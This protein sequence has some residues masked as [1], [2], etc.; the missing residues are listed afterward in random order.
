M[1]KAQQKI[2]A[3]YS[4]F[5]S[6]EQK[7]SSIDD[8]ITDCK[9]LADRE[10]YKV[11]RQLIFTDKA[12]SGTSRFDRDGMADLID[13]IRARKFDVLLCESQ[14]RLARDIEDYAFL[15]KRLK[16]SE[17]ILH[18][19]HD[20]VVA[21]DM[22]GSM[23][24][25]MDAEFIATLRKNVRRGMNGRARLGLR[26][27]QL[28]YGYRLVAGGKPGEWEIDPE[29]AKIVRRIFTEYANEVGVRDIA[30]GLTRDG[31]PTPK[32]RGGVA[33][34]HQAFLGGGDGGMLTNRLYIGE[35]VWGKQYIVKDL[36]THKANKRWR[37]ESEWIVTAVPHLRIISQE[38]WD[39]VQRLRESRTTKH[40]P[41]DL[42]IR[43][44]VNR[45]RDHLLSGL[46]KCGQCSSR[47]IICSVSRGNRFVKC[48]AAH[49]KNACDHQRQYDIDKLKKIVIDN[50]VK[51]DD[52][53]FEARQKRAYNLR[54]AKA[55]KH[56][57]G[58]ERASIE[59]QIAKLKMQQGRISDLITDGDLDVDVPAL[60]AKFK[61]KELERD[62][63]VERLR[64]LAGENVVP[65]PNAYDAYRKN[66]QEMHRRLIDEIEDGVT[67]M[68]FHNLI[69][70]IVVW[71]VAKGE[72]YVI[73]GYGRLPAD[74]IKKEKT[75]AAKGLP[76]AAMATRKVTP[77]WC[78]AV[79]AISLAPPGSCPPKSFEGTPTI[80]KPRS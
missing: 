24:S 2:A 75:T 80:I 44:T 18:T 4:R 76:R 30:V 65:L 57:N 55:A 43:P 35:S 64:R 60:K 54:F 51:P 74:S 36:D 12:K 67:R 34:G 5:S 20:G 26:P 66:V 37:P 48:G 11:D 29:K 41:G 28:T 45:N 71:P 47:M 63:L 42:L 25:M 14:S 69:D 10:G 40:G 52:P 77:Y 58:G 3:I 62:G 16:Q 50:L 68:M 46:L 56:D 22:M 31:I 78:C 72:Q 49:M 9:S 23:R 13:A 8:Q 27:G 17:I 19:T 6:D 73:D 33:W 39:K 1:I 79:S 53:E 32:V 70:S 21:H 15:S 7:E 59:K 61:A 38:L